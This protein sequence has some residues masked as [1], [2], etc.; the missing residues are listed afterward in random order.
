MLKPEML[1][2]RL[3]I[4]QVCADYDGLE[5]D[6]D[7]AEAFDA[8]TAADLAVAPDYLFVCEAYETVHFA[9]ALRDYYDF[10]CCVYTVLQKRGA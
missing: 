8:V 5:T 6:K 3:A 2:K 10:A 9:S 7:F 4:L 1:L